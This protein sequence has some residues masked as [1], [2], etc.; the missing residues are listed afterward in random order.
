MKGI[1]AVALV[2]SAMSLLTAQAAEAEMLVL[3]KA[4]GGQTIRL[5]TT[6]IQRNGRS[7]SWWAGFTYYLGNEPIEAGAHC[8]QKIW[9]VDGKT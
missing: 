9:S 1:Q 4:S 2:I 8:G 3:G 5:D 7:M 6:S